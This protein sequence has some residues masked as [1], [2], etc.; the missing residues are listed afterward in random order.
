[1]SQNIDKELATLQD[2]EVVEE[3]TENNLAHA[4]IAQESLVHM[5][6]TYKADIFKLKKTTEMLK[7]IRK[8]FDIMSHDLDY[9]LERYKLMNSRI[10]GQI[11]KY[12]DAQVKKGQLRDDISIDSL[13][14]QNLNDEMSMFEDR[15]IMDQIKGHEA[16]LEK[17]KQGDMIRRKK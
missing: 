10:T 8:K 2:V 3:N 15:I 1:M 13:F 16:K 17:L 9:E 6:E 4:I 11:Q 14:A 12:S 7:R 5:L